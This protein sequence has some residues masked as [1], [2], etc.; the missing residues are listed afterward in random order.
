MSPNVP[1]LR[2]DLLARLPAFVAAP[3]YARAAQ[4]SRI[5]HLGVGAFHRAHQAAYTDAVLADGGH[6]WTIVGVS[7]R[8]PDVAAQLN[9][10]QGLYTLIE[11]SGS[12]ERLRIIGALQHVLFAPDE[13]HTVIDALSAEQ[14]AVVTLTVT[15]KGYCRKPDGTLDFALAGP[16]TIYG[17]LAD[18]IT[19]RCAAD[20]PGLTI[21][22]CDNLAE[23]G[24]QLKRLLGEYLQR[25][26][27]SAL[28]WFE[29]ECRCPSSM[30]DRIVPATTDR[31]RARLAAQLG[32]RDAAAVVTEPFSQW[33]IEDNFAGPVP[34][35]KSAGAELTQDVHAH[36]TAKLR[37]LNGAHSA[38]AYLGLQRGY[39]FVHQAIADTTLAATVDRV[40]LAEAAASLKPTPG[41]DPMQYA[42]ALRRRFSN[43]ALPHRLMQIAMDGSQKI[44]QRW[45][46]TLKYHQAR[47]ESCPA[48]LTA[49]A[50]WLRHVR[51][52]QRVVDDPLAEPLAR[53][54][55]VAGVDGITEA[56]LGC[57]A[58]LTTDWRPT[59]GDREF[60]GKALRS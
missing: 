36:E 9:P 37:M 34:D 1:R 30:V 35:W 40:M 31:D 6:D 39:E 46:E 13:R 16:H 47:G 45:L 2:P 56:V 43:S 15:E 57:G 29:R 24:R 12:G 27:P 17:L 28:D 54:W 44:P 5:V 38:L 4:R 33:V 11:R 49:L 19:A 22:S 60:L 25:E 23:N 42:A 7:L 32:M 51:G 52:D 14:T 8:A 48:I 20:L 59:V 18:A 55:N 3:R 26:C 21:L 50:A 58:L 53:A 41:F 10:Q